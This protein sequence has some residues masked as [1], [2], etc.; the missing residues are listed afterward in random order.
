MKKYGVKGM[1][2]AA[3]SAS[4]ERAAHKVEGIEK[5]SVSLLTN[6]MTVEGNYDEQKLIEEIGKAGYAVTDFVENQE[7]DKADGETK[8]IFM[9]L[10][11]SAVLLIVLMYF[12]MGHNMFGL[13]LPSFFENDPVYI[14][15]VQ[16]LLSTA[17]LVIN[18]RFFVNGFKSLAKLSPNMDTLVALGSSV[19]YV[20]SIAV[21]VMMF[22]GNTDKHA[23]LHELYFESAAMIL[24]LITIGKMLESHSKGKT[25]D[26]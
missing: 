22:F 5:C 23:L 20:Y 1:S 4:V 9:R 21:L 24:V 19:S 10:I 17:I 14:A 11:V 2:C 18:N 13:P 12:A 8:S 7:D 3:C 16:L 25:T 6:S 15:L 26:A